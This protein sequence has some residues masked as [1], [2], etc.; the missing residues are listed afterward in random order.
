MPD[1]MR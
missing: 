1:N